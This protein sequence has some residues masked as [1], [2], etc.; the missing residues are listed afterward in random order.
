MRG[1]L[2]GAILGLLTAC[3][4][5]EHKDLKAPPEEKVSIPEGTELTFTSVYKTIIN[6]KCANCHDGFGEAQSFDTREDI[7][8][9]PGRIIPGNAKDS[10]LYQLVVAGLMPRKAPK[11]SPPE[12]ELIRQWIEAGAL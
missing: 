5:S 12:I 7:L 9:K 1:L 8:S 10:K 2:L 4:V 3:G 6:G 11:L